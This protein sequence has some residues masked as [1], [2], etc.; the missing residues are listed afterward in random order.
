MKATRK[1][2][3]YC[4]LGAG[5]AL[6]GARAA[7]GVHRAREQARQVMCV[8]NLKVLSMALDYYARENDGLFPDS[9]A[10]L[11]AY[12]DTGLA[13]LEFANQALVCPAFRRRYKREH[14]AP[15]RITG[16]F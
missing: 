10:A 5:I 13:D 12:P 4:V 15:Y 14:D 7:V 2:V 9:W 6:L 1:T 3:L 16:L 8:H 11:M